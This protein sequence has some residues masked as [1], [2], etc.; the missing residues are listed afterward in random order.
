MTI[1]GFRSIRVS[2]YMRGNWV[3][4]IVSAPNPVSLDQGFS[5]FLTIW[6]PIKELDILRHPIFSEGSHLLHDASTASC[7]IQ[8]CGLE[9]RK[10]NACQQ[11]TVERR[12]IMMRFKLFFIERTAMSQKLFYAVFSG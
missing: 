4:I 2:H 5:T 7:T 1:L 8:G 3:R 11:Q 9:K 12:T 10:L 6:Y